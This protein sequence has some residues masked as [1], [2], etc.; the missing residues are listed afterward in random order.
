MTIPF[1]MKKVLA[2]AGSNSSKSINHQLI[3]FTASLVAGSEIDVTVLDIRDWL[4]PIYSLDMDPDQTPAKI[5]ELISLIEAHDGFIISSPEHNGATPAFFKNILDW[6]SRRG[7][8]VFGQKP[9]LLMST[10]PGPK[11]GANHL[12]YLE[13]ALPY[14]GAA[15]ASTFSLPSFYKSMAEGKMVEE[16]LSQLQQ[17]VSAFTQEVSK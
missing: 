6:L 15:I 16:Q 9:V 10:S 17:S 14:Q 13:N 2:L 3:E 1:S 11:A 5:T 12:K 7:D 4:I 8:K